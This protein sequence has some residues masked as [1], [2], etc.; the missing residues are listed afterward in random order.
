MHNRKFFLTAF[1][2][3]VFWCFLSSCSDPPQLYLLSGAG[4]KVPI[5]EVAAD[6][7]RETGIRVETKFE[8]SSILREYILD[9]KTGDVFL[10]GDKKNL[11]ILFDKGLVKTTSF[12]AWHKVAIL[13]AP[14]Q[15]KR[16]KSLDDLAGKGVRLA[17][18]NP[19]LASLGQIVTNNIIDRHPKGKDILNNVVVYGSSSQDVLRLYREGG[20]DAIIEW[21]VM[22]ATPAGKGL[23]VIPINEPYQVNDKLYAGLLT[24]A[25]NPKLARKLFI[26]LTTKGKETFRKHGYDTMEFQ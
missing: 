20:I 11:D 8:G 3:V 5:T 1:L 7:E 17:M 13:V 10:P 15:T 22:A 6:F 18:S 25:T 4:M 12:I 21:D 2:T 24:T 9:F 19:R 16:I 23:T 26:Y 14:G